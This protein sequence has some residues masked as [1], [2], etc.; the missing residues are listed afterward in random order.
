MDKSIVVSPTAYAIEPL[1]EHPE[2]TILKSS[3]EPF[4]QE[5]GGH[6]FLKNRAHKKMVGYPRPENRM[7]GS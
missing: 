3:V 7:D 5:Y 1:F 2:V 6:F 4:E